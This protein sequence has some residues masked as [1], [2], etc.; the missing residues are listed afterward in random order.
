MKQAL[1]LFSLFYS[2]LTQYFLLIQFNRINNQYFLNISTKEK[3]PHNQKILY[4]Y[5]KSPLSFLRIFPCACYNQYKVEFFQRI[6]IS[7]LENRLMKITLYNQSLSFNQRKNKNYR[8]ISFMMKYNY[9]T[10][11]LINTII[12]LPQSKF[13]L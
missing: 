3:S 8:K 9:F 12:F 11:A 2:I 5:F 7:Q 10:Y 1:P 13:V 4:K 6:R